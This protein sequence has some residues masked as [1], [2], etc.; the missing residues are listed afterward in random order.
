MYF[1]CGS[2]MKEH[3]QTHNEAASCRAEQT[4]LLADGKLLFNHRSVNKLMTRW[5]H[6]QLHENYIKYNNTINSAS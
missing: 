5:L 3:K 6:D 1:G 4:R 2:E